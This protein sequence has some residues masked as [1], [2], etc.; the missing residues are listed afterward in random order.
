MADLFSDEPERGVRDMKPTEYEVRDPDGTVV[1]VHVRRDFRDAPKQMRWCLPGTRD[2]GL[3]GRSVA[4]LPLY[5][6]HRRAAW[7]DEDEVW[8]V[9]GEKAC[10]AL[11]TAGAAAVATY[12]A[13]HQPEPEPLGLLRGRR[14][15]LWP[16]A[17]DPGRKHML[18]IAKRLAGIAAEIRWLEPPDEAPKGWDAADLVGPGD[19]SK[20]A[21]ASVRER[22]REVPRASTDGHATVQPPAIAST[23]DILGAAARTVA[24]LGVAG[25]SRAVRL[26]YLVVVTRL[27]DKIVS[28]AVKGPSSAGKSYLVESVLRLFP[29]SACHVLSA[30]SERA[31]IYDDAPLEHRM[32]VIYEAAGMAGDTQ[33]YTVRSLLSEGRVR[34]VT[35][36]KGKDG[37]KPRTIERQGPTGLITTTTAIRLHPENETRMLSLTISDTSEQTAAV[38]LAQAAGG[39]APVDLEPWRQLQT[40]LAQSSNTVVIPYGVTLAQAIPPVAVRL[41]RD[42]PT[43]VALVK[44]HALLHQVRRDRDDQG[45]VVATIEDYAAVRELVADLVA[46]AAERSVPAS[47]RETVEQVGTLVLGGGETTVLALAQAMNLDKSAASR[48]VRAALDRGYLKNLE[49]RRGR[50][51]RLVLG[52]PLPAEQTILPEPEELERLH[53][54]SALAG[55]STAVVPTGVSPTREERAEGTSPRSEDADATARATA[56]STPQDEA[57]TVQRTDSGPDAKDNAHPLGGTRTNGYAWDDGTPLP[58]YRPGLNDVPTE[59]T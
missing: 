9:E 44:A 24:H 35:V 31:L 54:C 39:S 12:G 14:V 7:S 34:Y 45:A 23:D 58:E 50:P 48:R 21:L 11:W 42:F 40:W 17:D 49:D 6:A 59:I 20:A 47:V 52:D 37:L 38:L 18:D 8:V 51:S 4:S 2:H 33:S 43:V 3:G 13:S 57:A 29:E 19:D 36:E 30:F 41:R 55:G 15:V 56:G 10:E 32:L 22:I 28:L 26:I 53:G 46:D 16:D 27:L 1:A 25:E 5:G